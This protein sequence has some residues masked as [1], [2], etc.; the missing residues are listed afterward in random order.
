LRSSTSTPPPAFPTAQVTP[1]RPGVTPFSSSPHRPKVL[2]ASGHDDDDED[3][4]LEIL[5]LQ[6]G[7]DASEVDDTPDDNFQVARAAPAGTTT[8]QN[9][10]SG[11][12]ANSDSVAD[13]A[14]IDLVEARERIRLETIV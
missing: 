13:G 11:S 3:G 1:T 5:D 7:L 9:H 6:A 4:D 2:F 8:L 10:H 12:I 14:F